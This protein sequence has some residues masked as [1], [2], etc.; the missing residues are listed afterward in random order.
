M[1]IEVGAVELLQLQFLPQKYIAYVQ[2]AEG[3]FPMEVFM[4][5]VIPFFSL[6]SE[7]SFIVRF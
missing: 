4:S 5:C 2:S 1:C 6:F 3:E 7:F